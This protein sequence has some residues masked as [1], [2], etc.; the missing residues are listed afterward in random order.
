MKRIITLLLLLVAKSVFSQ[1]VRFGVRSLNL[2][3]VSLPSKPI[4]DK[5]NRTFTIKVDSDNANDFK[6]AKGNLEYNF[7]LDGFKRVNANG[8][9]EIVVHLINPIATTPNV[10]RM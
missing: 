2:S 4:L 6:D 7:G 10:Q 9:F 5:N 3:Y 8:Y 1:P